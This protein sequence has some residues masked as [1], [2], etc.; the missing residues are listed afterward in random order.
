MEQICREEQ[1]YQERDLGPL[2][3]EVEIVAASIPVPGPTV[4]TFLGLPRSWSPYNNL[5]LTLLL[6]HIPCVE[7][8]RVGLSSSHIK[9]LWLKYMQ[10]RYRV[11]S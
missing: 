3:G 8:A 6:P 4:M 5:C 2:K 7:P 10:N 9:E 1:R 11:R